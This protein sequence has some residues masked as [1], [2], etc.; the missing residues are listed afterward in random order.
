MRKEEIIIFFTWCD[1]KEWILIRI[2]TESNAT[3]PYPADKINSLI[4]GLWWP[5]AHM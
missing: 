4:D 2:C 3:V 1:E 5:L